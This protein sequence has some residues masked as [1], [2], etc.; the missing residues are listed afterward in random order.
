MY[1]ACGEQYAAAEAEEDGGHEALADV[2]LAALAPPEVT[3][4]VSVQSF[5]LFKKKLE[6]LSTT[7]G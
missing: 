7:Y 4:I 5:R 1:K 3:P 6:F 2:A